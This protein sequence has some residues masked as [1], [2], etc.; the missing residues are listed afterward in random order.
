MKYDFKDLAFIIHFR[1][2]VPERLRNLQIV[3][4]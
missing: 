4:Y 2:D 3:L 1:V